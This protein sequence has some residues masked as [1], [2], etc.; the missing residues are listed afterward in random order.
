[1]SVAPLAVTRPKAIE[2]VHQALAGNR[3]L[4]ALFQHGESED[5]PPSELAKVG[6]VT[7]IRQLARAPEGLRILVEGVSRARGTPA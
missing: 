2:A 7:L 1:M 6:T 4:L 3:M 5:P